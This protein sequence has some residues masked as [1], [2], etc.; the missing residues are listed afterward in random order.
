MERNGELTP[1][2]LV[3]ASKRKNAPLHDCFEWDDAVAAGKYRENQASYIIRSVEV[4]VSESEEPVR[5]FVSLDIDDAG[6]SYIDIVAAL[7]EEPTR[8]MVLA[9]ALSELKAFERKYEGLSELA[10]VIEAIRKVA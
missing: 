3:E 8:D 1:A 2:A 6:R 5:A 4:V 7:S 9:Q 10:S